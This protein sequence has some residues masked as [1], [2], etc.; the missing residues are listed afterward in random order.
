MLGKSSPLFWKRFAAPLCPLLTPK[1]WIEHAVEQEGMG[2]EDAAADYAET[3]DDGGDPCEEDEGFE[4][5][6]RDSSGKV[7]RVRTAKVYTSY[8]RATIEGIGEE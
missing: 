2:A 5:F 7:Y 3:L 6:V 1:A 8:F 4:L